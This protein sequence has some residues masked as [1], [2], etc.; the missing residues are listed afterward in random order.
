MRF[1]SAAASQG[2]ELPRIIVAAN[3][4]RTANAREQK[5]ERRLFLLRID[6]LRQFQFIN[7]V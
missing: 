4:V 7:A 6:V 1:G 3:G 2:D 5:N